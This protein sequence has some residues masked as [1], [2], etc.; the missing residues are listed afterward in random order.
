MG[1]III[2]TYGTFRDEQFSVDAEEGGHANAIQRA[3]EWL[4]D[5]LLD[6]IIMDHTLH[7]RGDVPPKA[8]FGK[9]GKNKE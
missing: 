7:D 9:G 6:A 5:R 8:W 4:N 2:E 1:M 3:I